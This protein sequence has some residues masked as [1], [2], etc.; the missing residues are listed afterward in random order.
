MP[1][2]PRMTVF[3]DNLY[4]KPARGSMLFLSGFQNPGC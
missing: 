4:A 3:S 2:P 1:H